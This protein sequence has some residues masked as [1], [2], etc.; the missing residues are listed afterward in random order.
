MPGCLH[1]RGTLIQEPSWLPY[2]DG[3][4]RIPMAEQ[5]LTEHDTY[6]RGATSAHACTCQT[7]A[8]AGEP[9]QALAEGEGYAS[10]QGRTVSQSGELVVPVAAT[11]TAPACLPKF[12]L[13]R[14]FE[15]FQDCAAEARKFGQVDSP[16]QLYQAFRKYAQMEDQ[17]VYY[18]LLFD[19][20]NY[21]RGFSE[22]AKGARD[23]VQTPIPDT[24]RIP[25]L[26]GA[27]GFAI[28]HNHPSGKASPSKAD[29]QVTRALEKATRAV[30][31]ILL[32][33]LVIGANEFYSFAAK[34]LFRVPRAT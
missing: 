7:S 31:L 21:L 12:S 20:H 9:M 6:E 15:S 16:L 8:Q 22:V 13:K 32:D 33:H 24:L 19:V 14:D 10:R 3:M 17:E 29:G 1:G 18:V 23:R 2:T 34:K 26:A 11:E 28:A 27:S 4:K 5:P 25:L 30:D